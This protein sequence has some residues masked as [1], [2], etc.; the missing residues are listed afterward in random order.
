M[1]Q[2]Y[3][4]QERAIALFGERI[5]GWKVG[6]IAE[7]LRASLGAERLA[8][9]IFASGLSS[10][11]PGETA[12]FPIFAGGFA[13]V[14][15]EFVLRLAA[16]A[17]A[18]KA[19]WTA[20]EALEAT[21]AL[22]IGIETAGSPLATINILGPTVVAS[23]FG[24]NTGLIL[25]PEIENGAARDPIELTCETWINGARIG[26]GSAASLLGGPVGSLVFLLEH[27]A[28]R[29]R[30]LRAGCLVTT[31]Q[32]T[33]IHDIQPEDAITV[34]FGALGEIRCEAVAPPPS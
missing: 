22:F 1:S 8:G 29:G 26:I 24:N 23:D 25:G 12:H 15:G 20:T 7:P 3:A 17:P 33:G 13:A 2:A 10:A 6:L 28:A 11:A 14:E 16:D 31:G 9:P 32:L 5:V 34:S 21:D 4:T 27:C 19:D 18:G 30:P